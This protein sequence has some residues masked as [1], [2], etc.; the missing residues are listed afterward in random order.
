ML[1]SRS[2]LAKMDGRPEQ[3]YLQK[4]M[5]NNILG[6]DNNMKDR[7]VVV[8]CWTSCQWLKGNNAHIHPVK[9]MISFKSSQKLAGNSKSPAN[10]REKYLLPIGWEQREAPT[11]P[12]KK[13]N[14][15][16]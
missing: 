7:L 2:S 5:P 10:Q 8:T 4:L 16:K 15:R 12:F 11:G 13:A 3:V 14:R 6:V 9:R 1:A